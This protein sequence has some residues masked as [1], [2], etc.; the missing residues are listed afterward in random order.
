MLSAS[1]IDAASSNDE[2][3]ENQ[4]LA[5][6]Q[7]RF[8]ESREPT[9]LGTVHTIEQ[10]RTGDRQ[11]KRWF[12]SLGSVVI[13]SVAV[14]ALGWMIFG[15]SHSDTHAVDRPAP[16][17]AKPTPNNGTELLVR[18]YTIPNPNGLQR[19][20][21]AF[22]GT[23][24]P[25][26]QSPVGFRI[27]GKVIARHVDTGQRVA[28]GQLLYQLDPHDATL[29][30]EVA[31]A[32]HLAAQSQLSQVVAEEAR[33]RELIGSGSA[34]KSDY[35]L[36]V[37][38]RD[39]ARARLDAAERRLK[40]AENQRTY[41]DL[42]ADHDGLVTQAIAEIG[43]FVAAGQPVLQWM[44]GDELEAVV[45]IPESLQA[46][47]R[48]HDVE[49]TFWSRA[50]VRV[51]GRLRELSPIANP[52]SR[53]FDARFQL[54]EPP[55]DLAIGMTATVHLSLDDAM[56][57]PIPMSAIASHN[58]MP[59][60]WKIEGEGHVVSVPVT[61]LRY[62]KDRALIQANLYEGDEVVS[63]GVQ[64]VDADCKVRVWKDAR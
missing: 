61:I 5:V 15:A 19:E 13:G 52:Q 64:R 20:R 4:V 32:D 23:L 44:Q 9:V 3:P 38:A 51:S 49:V 41:C 58:G 54:I 22:T 43:Q 7:P 40:L 10:A 31:R 24:Q 55:T 25:R 11:R 46:E 35:D 17:T 26:Y 45:S 27:A 16:T 57:I 59:S 28:R 48:K 6:P 33:L 30:L 2:T 37:A 63:A 50:G 47:I 62:E 29:Q 42:T 21:K 34:S 18:A 14:G 12:R 56:G 8:V 60:V 1:E 39:T 53:T 36:S